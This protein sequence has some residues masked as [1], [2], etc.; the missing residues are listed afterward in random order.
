MLKGREIVR[1]LDQVYD[2][3][4]Y[5]IP[6]ELRKVMN[7]ELSDISVTRQTDNVRTRVENSHG[8]LKDCF[9]QSVVQLAQAFDPKVDGARIF[10]DFI[11]RRDQ[12]LQ[13]RDAL[14]E[15]VRAV[16]G[17]QADK[18]E[19]TAGRMKERISNFYDH[20][21]KYL[22]Y[23]DWSGF[24]LFYIEILKCGS[25]TRLGA[26]RPPLRDLPGHAA[27]RGAEALASCRARR[28]AE[29]VQELLGP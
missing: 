10:P 4:V 11:A 9:Q 18:N 24:E 23:R 7:T 5:C 12:S 22:M 17:F 8:I 19:A 16:R 13:V 15:V 21:I 6:L 2:S 3:F 29:E 27:A 26:D 14:V 28:R 1:P 20:Y 25:M